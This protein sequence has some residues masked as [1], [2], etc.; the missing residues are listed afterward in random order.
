MARRPLRLPHMGNARTETLVVDNTLDVSGVSTLGALKADAAGFLLPISSAD[1]A[2]PN[3][4]VY[5]STDASKLVYKDA[6][7]S[8]NDLY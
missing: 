4:S 8:V 1:A 6:G 7:G 2:A 3:N 5:Y